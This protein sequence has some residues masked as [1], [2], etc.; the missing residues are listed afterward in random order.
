[1]VYGRDRRGCRRFAAVSREGELERRW[2]GEDVRATNFGR[3]GTLH[4]KG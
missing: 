3:G 4:R 2:Y 1:M